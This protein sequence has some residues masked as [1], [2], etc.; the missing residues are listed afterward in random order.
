MKVIR[1]IAY[2]AVALIL[3]GLFQL[4]IWALV[5]MEWAEKAGSKVRPFT[6]GNTDQKPSP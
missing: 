6:P 5:A 2:Y 1:T 4:L 3:A